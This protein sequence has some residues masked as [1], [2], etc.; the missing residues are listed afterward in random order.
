MDE[1][2]PVV[3]AQPDEQCVAGQPANCPAALRV[4]P[5]YWPA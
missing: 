1:R 5:L 4:P 2:E 3:E